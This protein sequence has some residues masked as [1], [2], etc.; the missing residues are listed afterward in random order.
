LTS[1]T[2]QGSPLIKSAR[3]MSR[4]EINRQIASE[5]ITVAKHLRGS[6]AQ[7][8]I[9]AKRIVGALL[10]TKNTDINKLHE[11]ARNLL[12][13]QAVGLIDTTTGLQRTY[14]EKKA[15]ESYNKTDISSTAKDKDNFENSHYQNESECVQDLVSS[16][17]LSLATAKEE[18]ARRFPQATKA[19][20]TT[21]TKN[22]GDKAG[23]VKT[24]VS[25]LKFGEI[26]Q[27]TA[28][29]PNWAYVIGLDESE[30][31]TASAT[32]IRS[33]SEVPSHYFPDAEYAMHRRRDAKEA[34]I[35]ER[36]QE[37]LRLKSAA[38]KNKP[39]WARIQE[40]WESR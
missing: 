37:T 4:D 10:R 32:Q 2:Y 31:P 35:A 40:Y 15:E 25:I 11:G 16:Q 13:R 22:L 18:C 3:V 38:D 14:P 8:I 5:I 24:T 26:K 39:A 17:S 28:E 20:V 36:E 7:R 19:G 30:L 21:F 33:A 9:G 34:L 27:A 6:A 23:A 1:A 12:I 29:I